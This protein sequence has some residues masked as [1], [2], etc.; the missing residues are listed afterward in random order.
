M[1]NISKQESIKASIGSVSAEQAAVSSEIT[2]VEAEKSSALDH[3]KKSAAQAKLG[4]LRHKESRLK[5]EVSFLQFE[6][7]NQTIAK[8]PIEKSLGFMQNFADHQQGFFEDSAFKFSEFAGSSNKSKEAYRLVREADKFWQEEGQFL[9]EL[10]GAGKSKENNA[11]LQTALRELFTLQLQMGSRFDADFANIE[12]GK[13][14]GS[15]REDISSAISEKK[16]QIR[17]L[18][19]SLSK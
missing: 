11:E 12:S 3:A 18:H 1:A 13:N 7:A 9:K 6:S 19:S 2:K 16:S 14:G 8:K 17:A 4:R 15:E 10:K 5:D